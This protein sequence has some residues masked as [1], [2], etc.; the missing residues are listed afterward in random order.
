MVKKKDIIRLQRESV[1]PIVKQKIITTLAERLEHKS[2]RS[3]FLKLCQRIEYT[4]RACASFH[5]L[6]PSACSLDC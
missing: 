5:V 2:D 4:I 3:E 1:I 6:D